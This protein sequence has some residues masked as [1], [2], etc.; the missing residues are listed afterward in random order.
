M[1]D[2]SKSLQFLE[3]DRRWQLLVRELQRHP[4]EQDVQ[5]YLALHLEDIKKST[6]LP[7]HQIRVAFAATYSPFYP[8]YRR[9]SERV[10]RILST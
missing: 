8:G 2:V 5:E 6:Q 1:A 10:K 3:V 7:E 4:T 9:F